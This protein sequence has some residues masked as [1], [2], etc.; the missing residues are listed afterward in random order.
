[1]VQSFTPQQLLAAQVPPLV[2]TRP[3][4]EPGVSLPLPTP[5]GAG[6]GPVKGRGLAEDPGPGAAGS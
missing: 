1:M 3:M 4:A 6:P 5:R 2:H